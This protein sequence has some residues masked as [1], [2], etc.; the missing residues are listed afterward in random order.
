MAYDSE[1][2]YKDIET[3]LKANLNTQLSAIDTEKGDFTLAPVDTDAYIFQTMNETVANYNPFLFFGES[4]AVAEG[5]GPHTKEE[6]TCMVLIVLE[7]RND[8]T[9]GFRLQRY[10]RALKKVFE[11]NWNSVNKHVKLTVKSI[12]PEPFGQTNSG[13]LVVAIGVTVEGSFA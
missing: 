5:I 4:E 7:V 2:F 3:V 6:L 13:D 10:R 1:Q 11:N 9:S 8:A 12:S